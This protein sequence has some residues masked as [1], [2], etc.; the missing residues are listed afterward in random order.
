MGREYPDGPVP[1]VG[2][3]I[4]KGNEIL[5]VRRGTEPIRGRWSLPGGVVELGETVR[6]AAERETQEECGVQIQATEVIEVL[7]AIT[8]DDDGHI[9]FH[10]VLTELL[11]DYVSGTPAPDSDALEARWFSLDGIG[12]LDML[13]ITLLVIREGAK[14]KTSMHS[15]TRPAEARAWQNEFWS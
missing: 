3:V 10:Y 13:S 8:R 2:V 1:A 11:A 15:N 4:L 14:L 12:D 7:D 9:R 5:L 6:Q